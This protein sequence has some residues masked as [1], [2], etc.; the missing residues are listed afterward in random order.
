ME[1]NPHTHAI[2][3]FPFS[4]HGQS[5]AKGHLSGKPEQQGVGVLI[6]RDVEGVAEGGDAEVTGTIVDILAFS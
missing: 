3:T 1:G 4:C 5:H 6:V 2:G